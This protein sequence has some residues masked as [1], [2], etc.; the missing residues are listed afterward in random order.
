[1][2]IIIQCDSPEERIQAWHLRAMWHHDRYIK[3]WQD[4]DIQ[5]EP[6]EECGAY[7]APSQGGPCIKPKGHLEKEH[8]CP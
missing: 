8:L 3:G 1:M 2:K 5:F 4:V 6:Y 7:W